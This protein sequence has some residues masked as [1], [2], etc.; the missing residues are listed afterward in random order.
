M[1]RSGALFVDD[2][3]KELG[4]CTA[5]ELDRACWKGG[6]RNDM[7]RM[8][9]VSPSESFDILLYAC[10]SQR[11]FQAMSSLTSSCHLLDTCE[12]RARVLG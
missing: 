2:L 8:G 12:A 5:A 10:F 11:D 7:D 4:F 6:T 9:L 3:N 1:R